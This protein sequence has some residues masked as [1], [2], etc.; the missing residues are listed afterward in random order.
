M[1]NRKSLNRIGF[2][3]YIAICWSTLA[4]GADRTSC[5][6]DTIKEKTNTTWYWQTK[7]V[8]TYNILNIRG[9]STSGSPFLDDNIFA[10]N[11]RNIYGFLTFENSANNFF[12]TPSNDS[13][14][15]LVELFGGTQNQKGGYFQLFQKEEKFDY[16][17]WGSLQSGKNFPF[18]DAYTARFPVSTNVKKGMVIANRIDTQ[19]E[20]G[21]MEINEIED[22]LHFE[23]WRVGGSISSSNNQVGHISLDAEYKQSK[24]LLYEPFGASFEQQTSF[25]TMLNVEKDNLN[26]RT[27]Y[28]NVQ[29]GSEKQPSYLLTTG[30]NTPIA[31]QHWDIEMTYELPIEQWNNSVLKLNTNHAFQQFQTRNQV[32]GRNES[33]DDYLVHGLGIGIEL[34]VFQKLNAAAQIDY[35]YFQPIKQGGIAYNAQLF[36]R[37]TKKHRFS[38]ELKQKA[39]IPSAFELFADLPIQT[40][41]FFD[42]WLRGNSVPQYP[43]SLP[44]I[45]WGLPDFNDTPL[46]AGFSANRAYLNWNETAKEALN[47]YFEENPTMLPSFNILETILTEEF[48]PNGFFNDFLLEDIITQKTS[49]V[50]TANRAKITYENLL[51]IHYEGQ[52]N[53]RMSLHLN[54]FYVY[55]RNVRQFNILTPTVRF[56]PGFGTDFGQTVQDRIQEPYEEF[57]VNVGFLDPVFAAQNAEEVGK[58][59]N[60]IYGQIGEGILSTYLENAL[61]FLGIVENNQTFENDRLTI[62]AG[63]PTF[64]AIQYWGLSGSFEVAASSN[65]T[66]NGRYRYLSDNVFGNITIDKQET[67]PNY[68]LNQPRN[69]FELGLSYQRSAFSG[70]LTYV[71]EEAFEAQY[72]FF[73][74]VVARKNLISAELN[75]EINKRC[76]IGLSGLNLLNFNYS[77]FAGL[78][79]VERQLL[80]RISYSIH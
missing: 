58:I 28:Q 47:T 63:Y 46:I 75:Y 41:E 23:D 70:N 60:Q 78:P 43:T 56:L 30:Y 27:A 72:G 16:R 9:L 39:N 38:M 17:V 80:L 2:G 15:V 8:N 42:I 7:T 67:L 66:V 1:I 34:S 54:P 19:M 64:D 74:G 26:F 24:G 11:K 4:Q 77:S 52:L 69:L 76:S 13:T 35:L 57:L 18:S 29:Q 40:N 73:S 36:Y 22:L 21:V 50:I 33:S 61:P 3:L 6:R 31:R 45:N 12:P 25:S 32:F 48:A 20:G 10:S 14:T 5:W 51:G 37:P 59:V 71:F 53:D 65:L 44:L 79:L 62:M 49:G 68:F 55:Q